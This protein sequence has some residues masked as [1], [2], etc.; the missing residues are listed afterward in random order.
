MTTNTSNPVP[1]IWD[2]VQELMIRLSPD[3]RDALRDGHAQV[4]YDEDQRRVICVYK[5]AIPVLSRDV[6]SV[7]AVPFASAVQLDNQFPPYTLTIEGMDSNYNGVSL[8]IPAPDHTDI[9]DTLT[10]PSDGVQRPTFGHSVLTPYFRTLCASSFIPGWTGSFSSVIHVSDFDVLDQTIQEAE[11]NLTPLQTHVME[12]IE[13]SFLSY[14]NCPNESD[15]KAVISNYL[16]IPMTRRSGKTDLIIKM[17]KLNP[18]L[19]ICVMVQDQSTKREHKSRGM[20]NVVCSTTELVGQ[21]WD[22]IF[23]DDTELP[24]YCWSGFADFGVRLFTQYWLVQ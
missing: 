19:K 18:D 11:I 23:F 6:F 16:P 8:Q 1:N 22:I 5:H 12:Y 15:I 10:L 14:V 24:I 2:Q 13:N 17:Q 3:M 20:K 7:P 4:I 21:H 9:V